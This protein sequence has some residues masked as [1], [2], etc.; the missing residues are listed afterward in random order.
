MPRPFGP[1]LEGRRILEPDLAQPL[2]LERLLRQRHAAVEHLRVALDA[3]ALEVEAADAVE[4]DARALGFGA[5]RLERE[6]I[7]GIADIAGHDGIEELP[8]E[9]AP[10]L[11]EARQHLLDRL[12]PA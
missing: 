3:S 7:A 10:A 11:G 4:G 1:R 6:A 8:A 5:R 12:A 2:R 9:V